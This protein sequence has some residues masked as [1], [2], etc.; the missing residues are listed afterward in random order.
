MRIMKLQM[1][2]RNCFLVPF[3]GPALLLPQRPR[4]EAGQQRQARDQPGDL[5]TDEAAMQA[6][7]PPGRGRQHLAGAREPPVERDP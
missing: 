7:Q 1:R 2:V 5:V 4:P 3:F 6:A